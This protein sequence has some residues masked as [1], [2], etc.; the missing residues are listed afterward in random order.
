MDLLERYLQAVGRFLPEATKDDTLAE[1]RENLLAQMEAREEDLG[2]SLTE[3]DTAAILTAH[4]KP[5]LVALRYLP[6]QSVIGPTVFPFYI[7]TLAR[8]LPLVVFVYAIAEGVSLVTSPHGSVASQL[9]RFAFG[10]IPTLLIF[11]G[12][13]TVIFAVIERAREQGK[14]GK[15]WNEWDPAKLPAVKSKAATVTPMSQVKRVI[16]LVFHCLWMAYVLWVPWHP[17]WIIGPGV[18]YLDTLGVALAPA[19]DTFYGLLITLLTVQLATK[20]LGFIGSAQRLLRPLKFAT[21][22]LGVAALGWMAW[23]STFFIPTNAATDL[24]Q[25][26]TVNHAMTIAFRIAVVFAVAGL[27]K[28]G[29]K[30]A[31]RW[32]P[33]AKLAF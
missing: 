2:R 16:D 4:G 29:W 10:L 32:M 9:V 19:W 14:L 21:D 26:A 5:E 31:K 25:I 17:F 6:Q 3:A 30:Y 22:L 15:K 12:V 27:V 18:F 1:L 11:L 33:A 13:V 8:A 28:D 20:L 7:F 23:T 24:R